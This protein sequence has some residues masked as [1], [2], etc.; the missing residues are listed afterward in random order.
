MEADRDMILRGTRPGPATVWWA[1]LVV[2][3]GGPVRSSDVEIGIGDQ[4]GGL[5]AAAD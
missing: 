2:R 1:G 3:S 4:R 5:V